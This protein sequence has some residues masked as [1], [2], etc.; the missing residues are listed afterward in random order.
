MFENGAAAYDPNSAAPNGAAADPYAQPAPAADPAAMGSQYDAGADPAAAGYGGEGYGTPGARGGFAGKRHDSEFIPGKLF[1]GGL[2]NKTTES[3]LRDYC[4]QWGELSDIVLMEGRGFGFVTF[5]EPASAQQFL[6]TREHVLDEKKIEAKAAV[7]R[8]SNSGN[9][10]TKKMFVGGTGEISDEE[11]RAYFAQYGDIDDC[12]VLRN[13]H[14]GSSR[15]FGFVTFRDEKSV[16]KCLVLTH[17]LNGRQVELKRAVEKDKMA[18]QQYGGAMPDAGGRGGRPSDWFCPDCNNKNFG[19]REVCNRC[20]AP[21]PAARY[22]PGP[23]RGGYGREDRGGRGGYGGGYGGYA[24][25]GGGYGGYAQQG[26]G[27]G[28]YAQQGGGY[29]QPPAQGYGAPAPAGGYGGPQQPAGDAGYGAGMVPGGAPMYVAPMGYMPSQPGGYQYPPQ[30]QGGGYGQ[31]PAA[32]AGYGQAAGGYGQQPY[33]QQPPGY[34]RAQGGRGGSSR[35]RP[36]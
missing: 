8:N 21:R 1:L 15:G 35:Y 2:S 11:F 19:W 22:A 20:Q 3:Q 34:G 13:K 4:L 31:Q 27:Y 30:Q 17:V 12:V 10:L 6:E 24:Q 33:A 5:K 16:E 18:A 25:Q 29:G 9:T 23:A 32:A 26:G 36:Y 14:D 28:G 7:P